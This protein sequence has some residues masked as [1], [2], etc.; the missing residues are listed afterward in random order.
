MAQSDKCTTDKCMITNAMDLLGKK[1]VVLVMY[2][3]LNGPR[4]F[5][6]LEADMAISGRLLSERLKD[7]EAANMVIR[8]IY[9]EIPPR[10]EYELTEK[11]KGIEPVIKEIYAW[12]EKWEAADLEH[13]KDLVDH[14]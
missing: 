3:L 9:P 12:A 2:K 6:E 10:V 1:W 14:K 4:R 5:T 11:G 13:S 8:R 7:L